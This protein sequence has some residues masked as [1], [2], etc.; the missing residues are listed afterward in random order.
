MPDPAIPPAAAPSSG[1][2]SFAS[3]DA[4]LESM[5][6]EI[7]ALQ[8]H[9]HA[10]KAPWYKSVPTLIS[11]FAFCFSF[12]TT[13][14]SLQRTRQLDVQSARAELRGFIQRLAAL[15]KE[16]LQLA[17]TYADDQIALGNLQS[18]IMQETTLVAKQAAEVI[19][20]IPDRVS[21]TEYSAVGYAL[22]T[23]GNNAT[24]MDFVKLAT[25]RAID[26]NDEAAVLR[27]YGG[28]LIASGDV[29]GG[30]EQYQKALEVFS[31]YPAYN[32]T[33][34]NSVHA[35]T[36][37]HWAQ[38]EGGAGNHSELAAHLAASEDFAH[39]AGAAGWSM[40]QQ[41]WQLR[42]SIAAGNAPPSTAPQPGG[43]PAGVFPAGAVLQ[44][45]PAPR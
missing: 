40:K 18:F 8:S 5:K 2:I 42:A 25:E 26:V 12:G 10:S 37:F 28:F 7:D 45:S 22:W 13:M 19:R 33:Y 30:R 9:V 36:H 32:D 35:Y 39:R 17:R 44:S 27:Q 14:L 29:N 20:R 16:N 6:R 3:L 41:I 24:A 23:T 21:A 4:R 1:E 11:L 38:S 15:P 34:Q 31:K 43:T